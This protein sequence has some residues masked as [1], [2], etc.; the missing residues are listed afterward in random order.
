M[1]G[2]VSGSFSK[3]LIQKTMF[4]LILIISGFLLG[5]FAITVVNGKLEF[6]FETTENGIKFSATL[7]ENFCKLL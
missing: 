3:I 5:L 7:G 4:N 1:G 6:H 2:Y